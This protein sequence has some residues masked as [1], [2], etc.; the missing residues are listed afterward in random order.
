MSPRDRRA[1]LLGT[2]LTVT[3][4]LALRGGPWVWRRIHE[5]V[6]RLRSRA[7]RVDR[8]QADIRSVK[9]LEDSAA[10]LR[11]KFI[12]LAPK[13]LTG[14]TSSEAL[15]DLAGRLVVI[16]ERHRVRLERTDPVTDSVRGGQ[17]SRVTVRG[18]IEGD[19]RGT[20]GFLSGLAA[21]PAVLTLDQVR[22]VAPEPGALATAPEVLRTELTI[23]GWYLNRERKP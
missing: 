2:M 7:E 19:T 6:E 3:A 1:L 23:Y 20:F 17:L 9:E 4:F 16:A 18:A 14:G 12:A 10:V 8:T 13:L 21:E 15:A 22:M 11:G 5:S